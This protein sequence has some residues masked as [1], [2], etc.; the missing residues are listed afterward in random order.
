MMHVLHSVHRI[1][2]YFKPP[3]QKKSLR[4]RSL[5]SHIHRDRDVTSGLPTSNYELD[6]NVSLTLDFR[7]F[8]ATLALDRSRT[9]MNWKHKRSPE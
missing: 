5:I 3:P 2:F 6:D 8:T 1:H 7:P 9:M 4:S